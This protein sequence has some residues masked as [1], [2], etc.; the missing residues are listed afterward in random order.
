MNKDLLDNLNALKA[1]LDTPAPEPLPEQDSRVGEA[2]AGQADTRNRSAWLSTRNG[3][4]EQLGKLL[5]KIIEE[6]TRKAVVT[7]L[8]RGAVSDELHRRTTRTEIAERLALAKK[9]LGEASAQISK[10]QQ[11]DED[12]PVSD[13]A[14]L[15]R[16]AQE[17]TNLE[18]ELARL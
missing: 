6:V 16:L 7:D 9:N 5:P 17:V 10:A 14:I 11:H 8:V 1:V 2:M 12:A 18:I 13:Y 4:F 15:G 3:A